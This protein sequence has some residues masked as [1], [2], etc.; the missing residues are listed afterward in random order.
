MESVDILLDPV[1]VFLA[2]VGVFLPRLLI[3]LVVLIGGWLLAKVIRFAIEKTLRALNFN[4]LTERAGMDGFLRQGGVQT[5]TS[6]IIGLLVYW[7]VILGALVIAFNGL[8][9]TYITELLGRVVLFVPHVIV[10]LVILAFGTYFARFVSETVIT[11]ARN[12]DL[13]DAELLGALARY[14]IITFVVLI[15]LDQL[16]IGGDIVR[17]SFLI[18]LAGVVLAVAL[19]FGLGGK[20]WAADKLERWWP[21]TRA[22]RSGRRPD[23]GDDLTP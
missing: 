19:A 1:R 21:S 17:E 3:A 9:L 18:I 13:K 20:D 7:L 11:Y 15:A 14:A 10:A 8:G 5:D 12:I 6:R 22:P 4:V 16:A 2:Q 23:D